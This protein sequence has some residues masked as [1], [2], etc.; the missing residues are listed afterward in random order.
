V[1]DT[2]ANAKLCGAAGISGEAARRVW[3]GFERGQHRWS[4]PWSLF[5]LLKWTERHGASV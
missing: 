1:A 5:V 4:K 2:L 3:Q